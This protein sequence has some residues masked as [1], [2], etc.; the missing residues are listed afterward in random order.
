MG[1][2]EIPGFQSVDADEVCAVF[3]NGERIC[4]ELRNGRIFQVDASEENF[5]SRM[6]ELVSTINRSKIF[7][8]RRF[9]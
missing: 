2:V 4:V 6:A 3:W 8:P 1:L 7:P 5:K 9:R